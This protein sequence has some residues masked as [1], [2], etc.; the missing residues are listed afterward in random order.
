MKSSFSMWLG[1]LALKNKLGNDPDV[2]IV[3]NCVMSQDHKETP[4]LLAAVERI[5]AKL[6]QEE[7]K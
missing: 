3:E 4:E 1:I 6:K 5:R 7:T 2:K